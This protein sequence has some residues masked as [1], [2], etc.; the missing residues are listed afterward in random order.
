[1]G[2]RVTGAPFIYKNLEAQARCLALYQAALARWPVPYEPIDVPTRFGCTRVLVSGPSEAPPLLLL[3]GQWSTATMWAPAILVLSRR[4]RAYAVDQIDD[5]GQS[6]PTRLPAG[7]P[8]YALWLADVLDQLGVDRA[9]VAGLSYGGFLGVNFALQYPGRVGRLALLCPGLP[10]LGP[11]TFRWALHGMPMMLLPTR[12]T[13][14]WLVAGLSVHGYRSGDPE[15]EQF[16]ASGLG[17]RSRMPFPPAFDDTEFSRLKMPVLLLVGAREAMYDARR[18]VE[19]ARE[20]F[21]G[22]EAEIIPNA[23]HMLLGDQ[24]EA[25]L[26]RVERFLS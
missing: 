26:S 19:R 23:G 22:I 21:P 24:P 18:A 2:V 16:I 25:T 13:A 15:A 5:V 4:H 3:H 20:L 6:V 12:L 9:D 11:A 1:M 7:R 17:L 14:Q 10:S 8:D